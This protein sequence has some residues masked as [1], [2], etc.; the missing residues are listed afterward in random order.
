MDQNFVRSL[1][2]I[3]T[4]TILW[5]TRI[6]TLLNELKPEKEIKVDSITIIWGDL[7][8]FGTIL[9][10]KSI[11]FPEETLVK[12]RHL[13]EIILT[14]EIDPKKHI[15][16]IKGINEVIGDP[17]SHLELPKL[18]SHNWLHDDIEVSSNIISNTHSLKILIKK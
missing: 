12:D 11:F 10:A 6:E 17:T 13:H 9:T 14:G 8:F 15:D 4:K 2:L 5:G 7:N 16:V 1:T 3:S 18:S